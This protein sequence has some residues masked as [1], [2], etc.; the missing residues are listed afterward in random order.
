YIDRFHALP[1]DDGGSGAGAPSLANLTARGGAWASVTTF[2]N[3]N[4]VITATQGNVFTAGGE[5]VQ[6]WQQLKAAGFISGNPADAGVAALPRNAFNGL[7]GVG[8]GVTPTAGTAVFSVC[9]SQ[10]PGKSARAIDTQMDDTVSNKGSVL[11]TTSAAVGVNQAPG[12][13]A[14]AYSDDNQYTICKSM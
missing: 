4:G 1:G 7:T 13:A 14:A 12:A 6:F 9:Q 5:T 3:N 2:G 8:T 11:A 10:V